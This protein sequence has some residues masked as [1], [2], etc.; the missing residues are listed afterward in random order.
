MKLVHPIYIERKLRLREDGNGLKYPGREE[1]IEYNS[2]PKNLVVGG[3]MENFGNRQ[4]IANIV[5]DYIEKENLMG[6]LW[7]NIF[8]SKQIL[9]KA[10]ENKWEIHYIW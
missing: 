5:R 4:F 1:S 2:D 3:D 7:D 6:N 10:N 8:E 9:E